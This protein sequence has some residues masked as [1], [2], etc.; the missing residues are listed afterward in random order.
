MKVRVCFAKHSVLY[1]PLLISTV[2][3]IVMKDQEALVLDK[4]VQDLVT[5]V[6]FS[7]LPPTTVWGLG[8]E[9]KLWLVKGS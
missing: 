8:R 4:K 2:S 5:Q 6:V 1:S 3:S 9:K 7:S